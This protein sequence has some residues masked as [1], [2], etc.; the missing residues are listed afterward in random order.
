MGYLRHTLNKQ[1]RC[2]VNN[3]TINSEQ[4]TI[5][6]VVVQPIKSV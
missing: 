4:L 5:Q 3:T 1:S 2:K 6:L